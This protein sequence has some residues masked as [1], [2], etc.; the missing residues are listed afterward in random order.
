M[1]LFL[2]N[3][4]IP[5]YII[6]CKPEEDNLYFSGMASSVLVSSAQNLAADGQ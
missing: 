1:G 6:S 5:S 2:K 4:S 3:V